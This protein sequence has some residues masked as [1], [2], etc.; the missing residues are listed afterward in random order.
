MFKGPYYHL[1]ALLGAGSICPPSGESQVQ[2][3]I[4]PSHWN[5][6]RECKM[7]RPKTSPKHQSGPIAHSWTQ[8]RSHITLGLRACKNIA[9]CFPSHNASGQVINF[10]PAFTKPRGPKQSKKRPRSHASCTLLACLQLAQIQSCAQPNSIGWV[11][12]RNTLTT[13]FYH[14][15][16]YDWAGYLTGHYDWP[17]AKL[18]NF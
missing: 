4:V 12:A 14:K 11:P 9:F 16:L 17:F 3:P 2:E 18:L 13:L 5:S 10:L 15:H 6:W 1:R 8:P 7:L